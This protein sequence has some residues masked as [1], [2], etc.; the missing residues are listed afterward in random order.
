MSD[1]I[2]PTFNVTGANS[3]YCRVN[4]INGDFSIE[5][6]LRE[7]AELAETLVNWVESK[8]EEIWQCVRLRESSNISNVYYKKSHG[9]M[10]V[11]FSNGALY[12][13]YGVSASL[14]EQWK[15]AES[16]G[17]FFN[18][19]I[20]SNSDIVYKRLESTVEEHLS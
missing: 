14:L 2:K 20:K 10:I 7:A 3:G 6:S 5:L 18:T 19:N 15:T 1:V 4:K 12:V 9:K 13:Y 11:E 8:T 17:K 16:V